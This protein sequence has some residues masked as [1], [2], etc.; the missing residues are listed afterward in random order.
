MGYNKEQ[1]CKVGL[2]PPAGGTPPQLREGNHFPV[3]AFSRSDILFG[4]GNF[5]AGATSWPGQLLGRGNFSAGA[6]S[7][8]EHFSA[9][10]TSRPEQLLGRS[11]F[12]AGATSWP[13]QLLGWSISRPGQLL[14][15]SNFLAEALLDR[16][17]SRPAQLDGRKITP[18][19]RSPIPAIAAAFAV[20]PIPPRLLQPPK[21]RP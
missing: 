12:L 1:F 3:D 17:A 18:L 4:R 7:W 9:E 11:N 20:S 8:L 21:I 10:A 19:H 2:F 16:G 5:L 6:T 15:W 14:G 13:G